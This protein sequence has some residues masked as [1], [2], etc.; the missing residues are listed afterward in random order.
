MVKKDGEE[1]PSASAGTAGRA[2]TYLWG[3]VAVTGHTNSDLISSVNT[4]RSQIEAV[5]AVALD[6]NT[7]AITGA[8][9]TFTISLNVTNW[10]SSSGLTTVTFTRIDSL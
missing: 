4:L 8:S 3:L 10:L 5:Q 1:R 6:L 9:V 7:S 2:L